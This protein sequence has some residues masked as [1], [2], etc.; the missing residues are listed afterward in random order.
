MNSPN[1]FPNCPLSEPFA[2][3]FRAKLCFALI[4]VGAERACHG[5]RDV[6]DFIYIRRSIK[7]SPSEINSMF[8]LQFKLIL[9]REA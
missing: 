3:D 2:C 1:P 9:D 7:R 6:T 4:Q 8:I 5:E